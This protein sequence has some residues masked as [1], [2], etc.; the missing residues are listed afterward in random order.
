MFEV[1]YKGGNGV[2]ISSAKASVVADP[3]TSLVGLKDLAVKD[4]IELATEARFALN[5]EAAKIV[6]ES[7][8][9]YGIADLDISG[10]AATR[11]LDTEADPKRS[12]MYRIDNGEIRIALVGNVFEN[13]SDDQLEA[14]GVIDLLILPVGG[15]GYTLDPTGAAGLTKKISPKAVLPIHYDDSALQY[16]VPQAS[17]EEFTEKLGAPV[18]ELSKLKLKNAAALPSVLTVYKLARS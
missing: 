4:R 7:P 14:L 8:G 1:E 2:V 12:T 15:G 10:V 18:E 16:E 9:E 13:I 17:L 6:I 11:H 3:K 5:D